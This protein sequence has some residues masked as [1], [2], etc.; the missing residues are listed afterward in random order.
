[1]PFAIVPWVLW[2][3]TRSILVAYPDSYF[4]SNIG[5]VIRIINSKRPAATEIG[6]IAEQRGA[7]TLLF[8]LEIMIIDADGIDHDIGFLDQVL[9]LAFRITAV[10]VAA[11]GDDQQSLFRIFCL[12]HLADTE[13]YSI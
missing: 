1:M 9:N 6:Y 8:G 13:V 3:V 5:Q 4:C 11:I 10:I 12:T 7:Q 2:T